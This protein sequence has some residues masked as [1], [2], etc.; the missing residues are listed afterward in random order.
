MTGLEPDAEP[1]HVLQVMDTHP[2]RPVVIDMTPEGEFRDP[3]PAGPMDRFLAR[4]GAA[5]AL[6]AMVAIGLA[7]IVL[8]FTALAVLVPVALVAGL[9]AWGAMRWRLH[10]LRRQGVTPNAQ[11]VPFRFVIIRR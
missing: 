6:A 9:V 1:G 10:R 3:P 11:G 5:A 7:V 2:R 8:A 4:A